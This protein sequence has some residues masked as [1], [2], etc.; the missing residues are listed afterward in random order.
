MR[1]EENFSNLRGFYTL[2]RSFPVN[3]V[4]GKNRHETRLLLVLSPAGR[5]EKDCWIRTI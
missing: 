1:W 5:T 3:F 4:S 2:N